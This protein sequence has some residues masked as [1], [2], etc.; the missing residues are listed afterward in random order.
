MSRPL[1]FS[2]DLFIAQ[3]GTPMTF[4]L[5]RCKNVEELQDFI[6]HG[7]GLVQ[8]SLGPYTVILEDDAQDSS[9]LK[10]ESFQSDFIIHCCSQNKILPLAQFRC[11]SI[12]C[13]S[14]GFN[15]NDI[16]QHKISWESAEHQYEKT[17][18]ESESEQSVSVEE[19]KH[20]LTQAN[21][22]KKRCKKRVEY[23]QHDRKK[24]VDFIV[25]TQSFDQV[26]GKTLWKRMELKIKNHSWQSLKEHFLKRVM[27][28]I[29]TFNLSK[30]EINKFRSG[31]KAGSH[32]PNSNKSKS[33]YSSHEDDL[34][35]N[36]VSCH[37]NSKTSLGGNVFW[38]KM[39]RKNYINDRTWQSVRERYL[40]HLRYQNPSDE[41]I[42]ES[43]EETAAKCATVETVP[44]A[45]QGPSKS[46]LMKPPCR[47]KRKLFSAVSKSSA[48]FS[49]IPVKKTKSHLVE[50]KFNNTT[51]KRFREIIVLS[52]DED[53]EGMN[54]NVNP[55]GPSLQ[56]SV[57]QHES[58]EISRD[59]HTT[60]PLNV[61]M[62]EDEGVNGGVDLSTTPVSHQFVPSNLSEKADEENCSAKSRF[63]HEESD[64]EWPSN[65]PPEE[66]EMVEVPLSDNDISEDE[67][68]DLEDSDWSGPGLLYGGGDAF[69]DGMSVK[70]QPE[71][72]LSVVKC[73]NGHGH[74]GSESAALEERPERQCETN[75]R[76]Q[77]EATVQDYLEAEKRDCPEVTS[78]HYESLQ[79]G[80]NREASFKFASQ[81]SNLYDQSVHTQVSFTGCNENGQLFSQSNFSEPVD[82]EGQDDSQ[83]ISHPGLQDTHL[84]ELHVLNT[85]EVTVNEDLKSVGVQVSPDNKNHVAVQTDPILVL[86]LGWMSLMSSGGLPSLPS[87]VP[88][89]MHD[90]CVSPVPAN[91][92]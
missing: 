35:L 71:A 4:N 67:A 20:R 21:G 7:G 2:K 47:Q 26:L 85:R 31:M 60:P 30:D 69:P 29:G 9:T 36:Y 18:E 42:S 1:S 90:G 3:D 46:L 75:N 80:T 89:T 78:T 88:T 58:N 6:E 84:E 77:C 16:L 43:G 25:Q 55:S 48:E 82:T 44:A 70:I 8:Q 40:K 83:Q 24:I 59:E 86:P 38:I 73:N 45:S 68:H 54:N 23:T 63:S 65:F 14:A 32:S 81:F 53:D 91:I 28:F 87:N 52:D 33:A 79:S 56:D 50:K 17:S 72:N 22:P 62:L 57:R 64:L 39:Q 11:N 76:D 5:T 66:V 92:M 27:P 61:G 51:L 41:T 19:T 37:A 12:S 13:F 10:Q 34:I 74:R 49:P 15:P